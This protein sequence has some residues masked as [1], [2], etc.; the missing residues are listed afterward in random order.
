[1]E[2]C[3]AFVLDLLFFFLLGSAIS[4]KIY[5]FICISDFDIQSGTQKYL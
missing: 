5:I 4:W 2:E 1:M 3:L